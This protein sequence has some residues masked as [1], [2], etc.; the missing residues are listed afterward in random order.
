M[1]AQAALPRSVRRGPPIT[2]ACECGERRDLK[3]GE[4]WQCDRCGRKYDTNR[5]P[6]DEY[7]AIRERQVRNRV[8]PTLVALL[9]VAAAVFLILQGRTIGAVV[10]VPSGAFLWNVFIR[11]ARRRRQYDAI[12]SLPRW[13]IK[14]D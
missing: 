8:A 13:Q 6:M 5:I 3:Y 14:A 1:P 9:I 11:P 7:A 10:I 2:V 4:R 12:K